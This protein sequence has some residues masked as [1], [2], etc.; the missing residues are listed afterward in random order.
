MTTVDVRVKEEDSL[1][2]NLFSAAQR[3][4]KT[5]AITH[6]GIIE[7]YE[8]IH[9]ICGARFSCPYFDEII[10]TINDVVRPGLLERGYGVRPNGDGLADKNFLDNANEYGY[11]S[12]HFFVEVPTVTNIFGEATPFICEI[13]ARSELQHIWAVKSHDLIYKAGDGWDPSDQHVINDM[14]M[15]SESLRAAD[16]SLVSIRDRIRR[17]NR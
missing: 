10:P 16:Q 1:L 7:A 8:Q 11:R 17:Q 2:K 5:T 3:I 13:Q 14:R 12:Y 4:A 6:E 9:D 15:L